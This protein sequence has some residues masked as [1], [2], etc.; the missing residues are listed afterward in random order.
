VPLHRQLPYRQ[1]P[2]HHRPKRR[3]MTRAQMTVKSQRSGT[4]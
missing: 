1:V 3:I 4:I 2:H